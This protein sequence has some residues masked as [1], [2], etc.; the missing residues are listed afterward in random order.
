MELYEKTAPITGNNGRCGPISASKRR[1]RLGVCHSEGTALPA[2]LKL[3]Q[4]LAL[5]N[6]ILNDKNKRISISGASP[7]LQ[8]RNAFRK[9]SAPATKHFPMMEIASGVMEAER[10]RRLSSSQLNRLVHQTQAHELDNEKS[11]SLTALS[12]GV[13]IISTPVAVMLYV[14]SLGQNPDHYWKW[15]LPRGNSRPASPGGVRRRCTY[16]ATPRGVRRHS[17]RRRYSLATLCDSSATSTWI[18]P[19]S[20]G[21]MMGD[22]MSSLS[23]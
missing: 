22:I 7:G 4:D 2:S 9:N 5:P 20:R 1:R 23:L 18:N 14:S 17:P 11:S 21:V 10:L 16:P 12:Y 15:A 6:H 13:S 19:S 3:L 8:R